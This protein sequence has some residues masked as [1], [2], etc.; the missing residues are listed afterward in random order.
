MACDMEPDPY[1]STMGC[2][3]GQK[4]SLQQ[5]EN[6]Q[7]CPACSSAKLCKED[8]EVVLSCTQAFKMAGI[9]SATA[10]VMTAP[11]VVHELV[12]QEPMP[13]KRRA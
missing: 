9:A 7:P 8:A 5:S 13:A 2:H 3:P 6:N 11:I 4:Q 1:A 10:Q 12:L